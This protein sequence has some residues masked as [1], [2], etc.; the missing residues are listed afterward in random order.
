M[1]LAWYGEA[2]G[3]QRA[4]ATRSA[5][6]LAGGVTT[7]GAVRTSCDAVLPE[8]VYHA[9]AVGMPLHTVSRLGWADHQ[10]LAERNAYPRYLAMTLFHLA[11]RASAQAPAA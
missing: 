2:H 1:K 11:E 3:D 5:E 10:A 7:S 6:F 9:D 4:R 8:V